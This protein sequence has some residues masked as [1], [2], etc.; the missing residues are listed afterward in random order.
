MAT[1]HDTRGGRF[2]HAIRVRKG[3]PL[4]H[5]AHTQ[6][7]DEPFRSSLSHVLHLWPTGLAIVTGRWQDSGLTEDEALLVALDGY[8]DAADV[9]DDEGHIVEQFERDEFL[10]GSDRD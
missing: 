8:G 5:R 3:T 6:E 9:V 4:H 2:W 1:T 10:V 7:V